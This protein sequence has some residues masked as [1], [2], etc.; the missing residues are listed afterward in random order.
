VF[1][2]AEAVQPSQDALPVCR[3]IRNP[4]GLVSLWDVFISPA[5]EFWFSAADMLRTSAYS[6]AHIAESFATGRVNE[7]LEQWCEKRFGY[8]ITTL[9]TLDMLVSNV[10]MPVSRQRIKK[11]LG[12]FSQKSV[13]TTDREADNRGRVRIRVLRQSTEKCQC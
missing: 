8:V 12:E 9:R 11:L 3:N 2:I 5:A 10:E 13:P 4:H 6:F 7:D 1:A